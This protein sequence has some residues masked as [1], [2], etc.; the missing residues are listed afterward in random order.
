MTPKVVILA[1]GEGKRM[2]GNKPFAP[3]GQSTLI[4]TTIARLKPQTRDIVINAGV[5]GT[6]LGLPLSCLGA[7]LI[8]DETLAGLGPLSGVLSALDMARATGDTSVITVPCDMPNLPDDMVAQLVAAPAADVVHFASARDYP[9][10]AL[11]QVSVAD[12]LRHALEKAESG[13]AVM[14]F[15]AT[16]KIERISVSDD[17]AFININHPPL[18]PG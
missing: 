17:A 2:G 13:L 1:G 8:F 18:A 14:R 11:W 12:A 16:Q 9:L 15:L 3:Y 4:E 6:A 7:R 5:R 10:C